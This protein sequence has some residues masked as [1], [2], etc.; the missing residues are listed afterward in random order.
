MYITSWAQNS[1]S[2]EVLALTEN[3]AKHI[4]MFFR[5]SDSW[6]E[7]YMLHVLADKLGAKVIVACP[8]FLPE[9][10]RERDYKD[11][12]IPSLRKMEKSDQI[13]FLTLMQEMRVKCLL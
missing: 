11:S 2:N 10:C 7:I 6:I 8:Q 1:C 9:Y 4:K 3:T 12:F 5:R 13:K